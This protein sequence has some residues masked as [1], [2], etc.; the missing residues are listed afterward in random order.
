MKTTTSVL[1]QA[2]LLVNL[3]VVVGLGANA[4]RGRQHINLCRDYHVHGP[5]SKK[6]VTPGSTEPKPPNTTMTNTT[7]TSSTNP[8]PAPQSNVMTFDNMT[9]IVGNPNR[10]GLDVIID[11]R[12][13]GPYGD[14]HIPGAVQFWPYAPDYYMSAVEVAM[15]AERVILYC[16][17]GECEDSH[18]AAEIFQQ[19]GVM[20][21]QIYIY[22]G[23]WEEWVAKDMPVES[24]GGGT[25]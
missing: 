23:G 18:M 25:P 24:N 3:G 17:G 9:K 5:T 7:G 13:D 20:P 4:L 8:K 1:I 19:Y 14:G 10:Y 6:A 22:S 12:D 16:N 15:A 21:Q 11:A 2:L